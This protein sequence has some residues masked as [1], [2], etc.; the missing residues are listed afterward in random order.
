MPSVVGVIEETSFDADGYQVAIL[1]DGSTISQASS[2]GL[3]GGA[4]DPGELLLAGDDGARWY[5]SLE[6]DG[7][8]CFPLRTR[9]RDDHDAVATELGIRLIKA[10]DFMAQGETDGIFDTPGYSFCVDERR[11]LTTYGG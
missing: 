9:G 11:R 8:G 1:T 10:P 7:P 2:T 3:L 6:P 4:F 5:A